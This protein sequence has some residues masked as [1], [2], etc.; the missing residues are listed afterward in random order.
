VNL[1]SDQVIVRLEMVITETTSKE[2]SGVL[3]FFDDVKFISAA[4]VELDS[5]ASSESTVSDAHNVPTGENTGLVVVSL[6]IVLVSFGCVV[7]LCSKKQ[8]NRT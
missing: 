6:L 2:V 5:A 8:Y 4:Q 3:L 7:T 1:P